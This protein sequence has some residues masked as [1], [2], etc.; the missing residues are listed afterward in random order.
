[1]TAGCLVLAAPVALL[2]QGGQAAVA[3][4]RPPAS[5]LQTIGGRHLGR[6]DVVTLKRVVNV[7]KLPPASSVPR[8]TIVEPP[9]TAP[10]TGPPRTTGIV[11]LSQ[12]TIR[13]AEP[14]A[15]ASSVEKVS[16]A[17]LANRGIPP[18]TNL[19]VSSKDVVEMVNTSA[20]VLS[21]AGAVIKTFDLGSLFSGTAG[22]GSDPKI[23]FDA[24][25]GDFFATYISSFVRPD[26]ASEVDIAVSN[27]P[28][29]TW[30]VYTVH[31][32]SILQDQPKVGVSSDKITMSWNDNGN[33]GPEEYKVIKKAGLV[34]HAASVPGT[35]WGPDSSR[36]NVVPAD[37]VSASGT[38]FAVFHNYDSSKLGVLAFT[39]V[40]GVSTTSFSETD[41]S[42]A[43]T[44]APPAAS[45]PPI[46]GHASPT[47]D[48]GDDRLESAVWSGGDLWA[49]GND[50]C[51]ASSDKS[52]R[53]CLRVVHI[54]TSQGSLVRDV[55]ITLVG[56]AVMYPA[57]MLDARKDLWIAFSSSSSS[58]NASSEVSEVPGGD[59]GATIGA[60]TYKTG[61]GVINYSSCTSPP[62]TRFGDYSGIGVDPARKDLGVW[63]A[64]EFGVAG[65]GW[66]TQIGSFTP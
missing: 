50:V 62:A 18:D 53:P 52:S 30:Y 38:A 49:A 60:T 46:G 58:Q 55:D 19:A 43:A 27:D 42:I 64:T 5:G 47:L 57:V 63:T 3:P 11:A 15:T 6:P 37:Q 20:E 41:F 65:C 32:E 29:G 34:A 21:H 61:S 24:S 35:I 40:P 22:Q 59:I 31:K 26:G 36:L 56:G 12:K 33:S 9:E 14:T 45:Q 13:S 7:A 23:V 17:G 51:R 54:S 10:V 16:V 8:P 2:A 4:L 44:S 39:G 66:G 1:M 48:T 25:S 28:A